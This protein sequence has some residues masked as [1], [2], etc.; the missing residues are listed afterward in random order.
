MH[1]VSKHLSSVVVLFALFL[2]GGCSTG[3]QTVESREA[4]ADASGYNNVLV[5]GIGEDYEG[6]TRFERKVS[7]DLADAGISATAMYVAA[8][9]NVPISRE[10][11]VELV[12]A[13]GFDAVLI[14]RVLARDA[15]T[16]IKEGSTATKAVRKDG[17]PFDL[18]RYDYEELNEP[19]DVDFQV[20]VTMYT[21]L[22]STAQDKQVWALES[23]IAA[24]DYMDLLI[25]EASE[26]IVWQLR[27]DKL[28]DN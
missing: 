12:E 27:R 23:N 17:R 10:Q 16:S 24:K 25:N 5:I 2:T 3:G 20:G 9:G 8:G 19:T 6:R 26:K 15:S 7:N 18:F 21:E 14:S 4:A 1:Q 28:L 13:N 11:V 22:F